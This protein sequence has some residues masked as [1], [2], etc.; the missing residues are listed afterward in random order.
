MIPRIIFAF[1]A[2]G[3][4]VAGIWFVWPTSFAELSDYASNME[5]WGKVVML[6]VV[7]ALLVGIY[8]IYNDAKR[9]GV[10]A[11]P[12][13]ILTVCTGSFGLFVY[14]TINYGKPENIPKQAP[15]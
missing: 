14:L 8:F 15:E 11:L 3:F 1:L 5:P 13:A 7:M 2:L 4:A 12:Y 6:D 10:N 9:K